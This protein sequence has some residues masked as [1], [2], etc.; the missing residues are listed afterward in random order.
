M[1]WD[2]L[3]PYVRGAKRVFIVSDGDLFLVNLASL[4]VGRRGY[5]IESGVLIHSLTAERDLVSPR[6]EAA[7]GRGLLALGSPAFD[8]PRLFAALSPRPPSTTGKGQVRDVGVFRGAHSTCGEFGSMRFELLPAS[9]REINQIAET[10]KSSG[11]SLPSR[12]LSRGG[13]SRAAPGTVIRL[14]GV[15][16]NEAAF[17]EQAP[18]KRILHVATHGFFL[19]ASCPS[20]LKPATDPDV[21]TELG[22]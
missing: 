9:G 11:Q 18:G 3:E 2:P 13:E 1:V 12:G 8:E 19:G 22:Q 7:E 4:P 14:S 15:D 5:L 17:K 10:W 20:A 6:D 21:G 16:A